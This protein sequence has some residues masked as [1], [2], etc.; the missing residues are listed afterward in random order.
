MGEE[1]AAPDRNVSEIAARQHGVVTTR[2]LNDAGLGRNAIG[3]R[4]R[5]GRLH[6]VHQGVYAVGYRGFSHEE[7]WMAAVLACCG[8]D[9]LDAGDAFLSHR[10]A[11]AL[12]QL[13]P[14]NQGMVDVAIIGEAGRAKRAGVR[15]H[16]PRTLET[17]MT[18]RRFG[19][20]VTKPARTIADLRLAPAS[21]GGGTPM[22][23]RRAIRQAGVL[24]LPLG[25]GRPPD[26][27]RSDLERLF[28]GICARHRLATPRVNVE[29][30][31]MEVDFLWR[32]RRLIVETDGYR[33]HRGRGAFE[34]DRRRDLRLRQLGYEVVR[35]SDDQVEKESRQV[36]AVL[37]RLLHAAT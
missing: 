22:Q 27:T 14:P 19:I 1:L 28:L 3:R 5:A 12:W 4:M 36:A 18:G 23:V 17:E 16:R 2:Q 35:L 8:Y 10:S 32:E 13:L 29:V 11:A 24:G 30:G 9:G 7:R 33:Y 15:A 20:P 34:E 25:P 37:R 6:R 31:G 21:R 26:R